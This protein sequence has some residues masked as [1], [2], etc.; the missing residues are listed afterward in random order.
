MEE[1]TIDAERARAARDELQPLLAGWIDRLSRLPGFTEFQ[2]TKVS[3]ALGHLDGFT[4]TA[5]THQ[6][7]KFNPEWDRQHRIVSAYYELRSVQQDI[8]ESAY[9]FRRF[10]FRGLPVTRA[11]HLRMCCELYFGR[12]FKLRERYT[13][14]LK[15]MHRKGGA[16]WLEV[17][18]LVEQLVRQFHHEIEAR[19][20]A[21]HEAAFVD[22]DLAAL[23]VAGLLETG[24]DTR[25]WDTAATITYRRA[26]KL[27]VSRVE[28]SAEKAD[29][30]VGAA[31]AILLRSAK[32]LRE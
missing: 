21:E 12:L 26:C 14:F 24:D 13:V 9:Y 3:V 11:S 1:F 8:R 17:D 16:K 30:Y 27:W 15:L 31:A 32:F 18:P 2:K 23:T 29:I 20:R 6:E 19:K 5:D 28:D 7:F 22:L 25:G 4:P 10:P